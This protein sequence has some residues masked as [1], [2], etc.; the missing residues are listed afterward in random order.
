MS[1]VDDNNLNQN[2]IF[3]LG[4]PPPELPQGSTGLPMWNIP[5]VQQK[6]ELDFDPGLPWEEQAKLLRARGPQGNPD[7]EAL[8]AAHKEL[9]LAWWPHVYYAQSEYLEGKF[10]VNVAGVLTHAL[11]YQKDYQKAHKGQP[12]EAVVKRRAEREQRNAENEEYGLRYRAW[13]EDCAARLKWMTEK[14]QEWKKR[15]KERN[16]AM[17]QWAAYVEEARTAYREAQRTDAPRMPER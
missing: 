12:S 14:Q 11:G 1:T 9:V 17:A 4:A 2:E 7:F 3:D 10:A 6:V 5:N 15:I 8:P 16:E 13:Q